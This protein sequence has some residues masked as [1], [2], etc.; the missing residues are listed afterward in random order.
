MDKMKPREVG[1]MVSR[2]KCIYVWVPYLETEDTDHGIWLAVKK[3][4]ARDILNA[5]KEDDH[6]VFACERRGEVYIGCGPD[7]E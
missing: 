2:A 3:S 6:L 7:P 5:A 4:Q 1:G